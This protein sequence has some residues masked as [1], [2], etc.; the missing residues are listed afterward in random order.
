MC[1]DKELILFLYHIKL[2]FSVLILII[3][4]EASCWP[5]LYFKN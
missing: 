3:Q 1:E 5:L 4:A 2:K